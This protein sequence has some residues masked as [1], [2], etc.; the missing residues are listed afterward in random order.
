MWRYVM[1]ILTAIFLIISG[2]VLIGAAGNKVPLIGKWL[3]EAGGWLAGFAVIIGIVDIIIGII[4]L[5]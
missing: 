1:G 4:A 2:L 3:A 5:F